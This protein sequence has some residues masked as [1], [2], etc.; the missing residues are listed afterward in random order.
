MNLSDVASELGLTVLCGEDN[1]AREVSGCYVSDLLSDV[2]GNAAEGQVWVTLQL[3]VNVVAVAALRDLAGI[4]L[5]NSRTPAEETL[6]K[7]AEE[8]LP[9]LST[10]LS[11]YEVSGRLYALGIG[12]HAAQED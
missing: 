8:G 12:T 1:L 4:I 7:A 10:S 9:L 6:A 11:T 3:H 2:M 5:V